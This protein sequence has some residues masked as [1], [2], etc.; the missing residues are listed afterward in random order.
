MCLERRGRGWD[1]AE[2][3]EGGER[4]RERE[5]DKIEGERERGERGS[6]LVMTCLVKRGRCEGVS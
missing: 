6:G 2:K 5:R 4:E 1:G 3:R